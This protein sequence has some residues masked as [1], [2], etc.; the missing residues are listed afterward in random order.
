MIRT[1]WSITLY[2]SNM[3][4]AVK[5]YG[6]TLG[7][8]KKYGFPSYAGFECGGVEIGL[9]PTSEPERKTSPASPSVQFLVDDVHKFCDRLNHA[10]VK[11]I[12]ELH[13]E[14]WGG[15]QATFSDPDGNILEVTQIDWKKYF[16]VSAE[17]AKKT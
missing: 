5:F 3:E 4:R 11:F 9:I 7:L 10:G 2:V 13:D 8:E 1:V 14:T 17:G 16:S 12:K 15:R 6:E